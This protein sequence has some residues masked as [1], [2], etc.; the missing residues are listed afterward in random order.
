MKSG[1]ACLSFDRKSSKSSISARVSKTNSVL[2]WMMED[3]VERHRESRTIVNQSTFF[4]STVS[5]SGRC[6]TSREMQN[7]SKECKKGNKC[8]HPRFGIGFG[9]TREGLTEWF[10]DQGIDI[11]TPSLS[12]Y[13]FYS[14]CNVLRM[15]DINLL[16]YKMRS[17]EGPV[18]IFRNKEISKSTEVAVMML[19]N[20][21][22]FSGVY[23]PA[24]TISE[25][26][27]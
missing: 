20:C 27:K 23:F 2:A 18:N 4:L 12:L 10:G 26:P 3:S 7:N 25:P 22:N 11:L 19:C 15:Q 24:T 6:V 14:A 17:I 9:M 5:E 1:S 16:I 13:C 8:I 21:S